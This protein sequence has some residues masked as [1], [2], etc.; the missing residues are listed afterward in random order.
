MTDERFGALITVIGPPAEGLVSLDS[1]AAYAAAEK[2]EATRRAYAGDFTHFRAWC[3]SHSAVA[4][5][6]NKRSTPAAPWGSSP[7]D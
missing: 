2:S 4:R 5:R 1:A 3:E 6:P 7:P